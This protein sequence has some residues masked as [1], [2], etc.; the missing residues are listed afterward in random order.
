MTRAALYL[1]GCGLGA[2]SVALLVAAVVQADL[3]SIG[4]GRRAAQSVE[5]DPPVTALGV[6]GPQE[7]HAVSATVAN[8]FGAVARL[9]RTSKTCSCTEVETSKSVLAPG[10]TATVSLV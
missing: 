10:D 2:A 5:V 8:R 3:G 1:A 7:S 4:S 6:V 9:V